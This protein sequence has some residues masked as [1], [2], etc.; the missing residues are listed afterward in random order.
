MA[1]LELGVTGGTTISATRKKCL[2]FPG[3]VGGVWSWI[4]RKS[5]TQGAIAKR[6]W[7][8]KT[9]QDNIE[10]LRGVF[11]HAAA[12]AIQAGATVKA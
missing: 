9:I 7:L 6:P 1:Y 4:C 12:A 8:N 3:Y 5:V 2:C 11:E 10:T